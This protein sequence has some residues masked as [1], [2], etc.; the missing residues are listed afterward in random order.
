M[1]IVT[2]KCNVLTYTE[3]SFCLWSTD[4]AERLEK[5]TISFNQE[6]QNNLFADWIN[7]F[8]PMYFLQHETGFKQV[9]RVEA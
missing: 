3:I 6:A 4:L 1:L 8:G 2:G 5:K 7:R 9:G